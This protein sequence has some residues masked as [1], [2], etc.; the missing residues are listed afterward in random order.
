[1]I[2]EVGTH[3]GYTT[4]VLA[5]VAKKVLALDILRENLDV[6]AKT[7]GHLVEKVTFLQMDSLA[8]APRLLTQLHSMHG[9]MYMCTIYHYI[10]II[11]DMAYMAT[12]SQDVLLL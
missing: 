3:H 4:A 12:V 5:A 11:I 10:Y 1:M 8:E 6:A 7:V 9:Y 2:L